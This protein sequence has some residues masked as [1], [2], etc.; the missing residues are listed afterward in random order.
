MTPPVS[1]RRIGPVLVYATRYAI[2]RRSGAA[3]DVEAAISANLASLDDGCRQAIC[4]DII[5]ASDYGDECDRECWMRIL[6]RLQ[7]V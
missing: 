7:H 1:A 5:E 6:E 4:R 3:S 2:G